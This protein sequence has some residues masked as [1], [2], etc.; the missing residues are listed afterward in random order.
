MVSF[1]FLVLL[2][3]STFLFF[4]TFSSSLSCGSAMVIN[5]KVWQGKVRQGK[6]SFPYPTRYA[7]HAALSVLAFF[8]K[9]TRRKGRREKKALSLL[10]DAVE[11]GRLQKR[12]RKQKQLQLQHYTYPVHVHVPAR[13]P[14]VSRQKLEP[15]YD[16]VFVNGNP[17]ITLPYLCGPG[18][19][20]RDGIR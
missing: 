14:V 12:K 17:E 13:P 5:Y 19:A 7:L 2:F 10:S 4:A 18:P 20:L 11:N 6:I 1:F 15:G 3:R 8:Q 9:R 16:D